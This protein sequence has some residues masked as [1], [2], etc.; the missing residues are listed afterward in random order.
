MHIY[1]SGGP[2]QLE[3]ADGINCGWSRVARGS[4]ACG[5]WRVALPRPIDEK[6]PGLVLAS[7]RQ[8]CVALCWSVVFESCP[9]ILI[10]TM[11]PHG[12]A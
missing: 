5:V 7:L 6:Y 8:D 4:H 11:I 9:T 2:P 12:K 10:K 1:K 3:P